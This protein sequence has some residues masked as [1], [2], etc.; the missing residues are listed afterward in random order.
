[1]GASIRPRIEEGRRVEYRPRSGHPRISRALRSGAPDLSIGWSEASR[2][3]PRIIVRRAV[4]EVHW[5]VACD[6]KALASPHGHRSAGA[7]SRSILQGPGQSLCPD[8]R[9]REGFARPVGNR[10]RDRHGPRHP[11]TVVD[12]QIELDANRVDTGGTQR[13]ARRWESP[14]PAQENG[15]VKPIVGRKSRHRFAGNSWRCIQVRGH[16]NPGCLGQ[17]NLARGRGRRRELRS[18]DDIGRPAAQRLGRPPTD[19]IRRTVRIHS[20]PGIQGDPRGPKAQ[21]P[22]C[23]DQASRQQDRRPHDARDA[24]VATLVEFVVAGK[25]TGRRFEP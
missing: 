20:H 18:K 1:M 12:P 19:W 24:H 5:S 2:R 14:G 15:R 3:R 9:R 17:G 13:A 6:P 23:E 25:T 7:M 8:E 16:G 4:I 10:L 22:A 11:A 21:A